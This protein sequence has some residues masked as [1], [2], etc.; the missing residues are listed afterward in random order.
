MNLHDLPTLDNRSTTVRARASAGADERAAW[1]SLWREA[2][3]RYRRAGR[4]AFH[5]ARGK[6]RH[7][8]VFQALLAQ[9]DI[10][11]GARVLDIGCGQGLL[12][13]L[14]AACDTCAARGGWPAR[15]P[16][17]PTATHYRGIELMARDVARA[18]T[19]LHGLPRSPRVQCGDMR[20]A[21]F[22]PCDVVVILDVL[23]YVSVHE[24]DDVLARVHAALVPRGRLLLR[25]GDAGARWRHTLTRWVDRTVTLVRGHT[26]PPLASRTLAQW[27]AALQGLGFTVQVRPMHQGTPFANMLLVC[28]KAPVESSR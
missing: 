3:E 20:S 24:Q 23:H 9:G 1:P 14:L 28:A 15:W 25:V 17:T 27:M 19:A 6:L 13:S 5:F 12:A 18:E 7:D 2:A 21:A 22:D 4:F 26:A 16:P 8:P 11:P 10:A